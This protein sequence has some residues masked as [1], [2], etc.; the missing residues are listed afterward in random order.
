MAGPPSGR[1]TVIANF[2]RTR[3]ANLL[4]RTVNQNGGPKDATGRDRQTNDDIADDG[5]C[6]DYAHQSEKSDLSF[7][8][9]KNYS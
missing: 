9:G 6:D 3:V 5:H 4:V 1:A 7:A 2:V 8:H